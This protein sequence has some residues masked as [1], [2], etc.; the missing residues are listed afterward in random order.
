MNPPFQR[1]DPAA[2]AEVLTDD[3]HCLGS[4]PRGVWPSDVWLRRCGAAAL[5]VVLLASCRGF[6]V[7]AQA[8]DR[9]VADG[10]P[11]LPAALRQDASRYLESRA[12]SFQ[13][14]HPERVEM[15][16]AT[17][18]AEA[19]QLHLVRAPG[20]ARRQLTFFDEPVAGGWF[21]PRE[22]QFIVFQQDVGGGE[23]YQL[24]RYDLSDGRVT[25]LTDGKSR[26]SGPCWSDSGKWLAYTSTRRNG[27]DTDL[28]VIDPSNPK[29]DRRL[30][31]LSGGGW[32]AM[33]WSA[34]DTRL[35]VGESISINESYLYVVDVQSGALRLL[36][37]KTGET[38][39]WQSAQ[40]DKDGRSVLV[41]SDKD[42]EFRRLCRLDVATGDVMPLTAAI[43]WDVEEFDVTDDGQTVA[44]VTNEDG[45]SVLHLMDARSGQALPE[46][47]L[48]SGVIRGLAWHANGRHLACTISSARSPSDAYALDIATGQ[49][50]R[51]TESETGGLNPDS[52]VEPELVRIESFD[53]L[54]I[55][56]FV[57]RPDPT[58]FPGPRPVLIN[59]HGGPE[60]Q[61]RPVFQA[62]NNY[63]LNELGVAVVHPNVRGSAGYGKTFLTLDNGFKREDSVRD[64][65][66]IIEWIRQDKRWDG[67]R[68]AVMGGSYGGYMVL[69]SM[70]HFGDM[71][72]CGVD[73]VGI[74]N[75][76]TFLENTQDYR[77]D[78]RRVEYGD[79]RDAKMAE[80]LGRISPTAQAAKIRKA[81]F[82]AQGQNDPRV[83]VSESEQ[84]VKAIRGHGG[85]VWYLK[86]EDEGHGFRKKKNADYQFLAT[87]LFL[88]EHLLDATAPSM[89]VNAGA[90][91]PAQAERLSPA[92]AH[93][94]FGYYDL[95][96]VDAATGRHL[97][98]RVPFCDRLPVA[99]DEAELGLINLK[100]EGMFRPFART[101]AWNFQQGAL[102]QWLG[103]GTGRVFYN[104]VCPEGGGYRGVLH[105][106]ATNERR[107]TDRALA[108]ISRDGRWGLAVDFDRMHD[109]R[110]GYGYA[111]QDDPRGEVPHPADDGV[112]VCDLSTGAS[113]LVLS[114]AALHERVR[115]LSP[116][117][118]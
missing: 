32:S 93:V 38:V 104:D 16:V 58:K 44:F 65:G 92:D 95:P 40:F 102:L 76:L 36:T 85:R 79:E 52:F 90:A 74:S 8:P 87:V 84:M 12:A 98:H 23:F 25:L 35:L 75:F 34:D 91:A 77:R 41:A 113:R 47:K 109:F 17:R 24:Y 18:F 86:A 9:L 42:S 13:S 64:I 105:D 45:V 114:L 7:Q 39:A 112:W 48:P 37:P 5:L 33:D 81:L 43:G 99:G 70:I 15:L 68:I 73:V 82:V 106:I 107:F 111:A 63:Y 20:S 80:F 115:A 14:W 94:F 117:M 53:G 88:E 72:R 56:A 28:Y 59:I 78:L 54:R 100:G 83:P 60:S 110:P 29:S 26:N 57:F 27:K 49:V 19:V 1:A 51:W 55:S 97:A 50:A 21:Q 61:S 30:I 46:P 103:D 4:G 89:A 118:E 62:R 11:A 31:E 66:A 10:I 101:R 22:G 69:A 3:G 6:C 108:N 67:E 116:L 96:A 2:A 71:L